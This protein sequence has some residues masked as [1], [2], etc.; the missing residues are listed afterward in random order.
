[1]KLAL[2]L[3]LVGSFLSACTISNVNTT[4]R[5]IRNRPFFLGESEVLVCKRPYYENSSC[6]VGRAFSN[7]DE[8]TTISFPNGGYVKAKDTECN[9]TAIG[10]H[11]VC[12]VWDQQDNTWD[13]FEININVD[14]L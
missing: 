12:L 4:D 5:T 8:I 11:P 3:I 6:F 1:M 2:L 14:V 10:N 13:I 9:V 7:G